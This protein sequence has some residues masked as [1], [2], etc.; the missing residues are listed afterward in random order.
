MMKKKAR[1]VAA[2]IKRSGRSDCEENFR[3]SSANSSIIALMKKSYEVL[4]VLKSIK[5]AD[6]LRSV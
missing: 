1:S 4:E 5:G 2:I 3:C 6:P